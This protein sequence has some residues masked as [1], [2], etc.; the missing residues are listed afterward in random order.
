MTRNEYL[1]IVAVIESL[2]LQQIKLRRA[3]RDHIL[4]YT[5]PRIVKAAKAL[6]GRYDSK[7]T[8]T[9][10]LRK[11]FRDSHDLSLY[12][13]KEIIDAIQRESKQ[14]ASEALRVESAGT[15]DQCPK[16]DSNLLY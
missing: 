7:S 11:A 3:I 10:E 13:A 14:R 9:I 15:L 5:D 6:F 2:A 4:K 8:A 12:E 1:A 16:D